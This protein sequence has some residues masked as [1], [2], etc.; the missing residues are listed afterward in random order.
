[1]AFSYGAIY[2]LTLTDA[3]T[4]Y[5]QQFNSGLRSFTV[6]ARQAGA[7]VK[8]ALVSGSSGTNYITIPAGSSYELSPAVTSKRDDVFTLY[9]QSPVAGTILEIIGWF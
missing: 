5:S 4:E 9:F 2:N 8:L 6:K 3:D 7:A 1:M